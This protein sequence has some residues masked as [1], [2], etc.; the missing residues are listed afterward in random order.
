MICLIDELRMRDS[1]VRKPKQNLDL[2][3]DKRDVKLVL[4][5]TCALFNEGELSEMCK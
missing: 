3:K 4:Y 2:V 5:G 1:F